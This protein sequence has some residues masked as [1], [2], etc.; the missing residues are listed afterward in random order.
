M[1]IFISSIGIYSYCMNYNSLYNLIL[2]NFYL[3][4]PSKCSWISTRNICHQKCH[5]V[6]K[7][8]P[9]TLLCLNLIL[10]KNLIGLLWFFDIGYLRSYRPFL[11]ILEYYSKK[12]IQ[13]IYASYCCIECY[14]YIILKDIPFGSLS[15]ITYSGHF[16]YPNVYIY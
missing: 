1:V 15:T 3:E 5:T 12:K 8:N 14:C 11:S 16:S 7:P 13:N 10:P 9:Y 6:W 2:M 4:T